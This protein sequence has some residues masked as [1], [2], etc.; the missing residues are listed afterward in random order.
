MELPAVASLL[1]LTLISTCWLQSEGRPVPAAGPRPCTPAEHYIPK[2]LPNRG[3]CVVK[4]ESV[5]PICLYVYFYHNY[6]K[7]DNIKIVCYRV[8]YTIIFRLDG[9]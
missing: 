2:C 8:Y 3:L 9:T 1:L 7:I 4:Y 5:G 6:I